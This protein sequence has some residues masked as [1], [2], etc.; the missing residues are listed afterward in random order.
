MTFFEFRFDPVA[1]VPKSSLLSDMRNLINNETFSDVTFIVEG[2]KVYGSRIHL[3]ARS[4][5]FKAMLY[6]GMKESFANDGVEI[7]DISYEVFLKVL[8]FLYTDEVEEIPSEMAVHL[9][10]ASERFLLVRLKSLCEGA[11]RKSVTPENVVSTLLAA[12][13]HHAESLRTM[14]LDFVLD[15]LDLVKATPSFSQLK[16][17]P[18]LLMEIIMRSST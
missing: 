11:I 17:E 14:T 5:H 8:E 7:E 9:L 16:T 6:G 10:M 3:A 4:E 18:D 13:I 15:N 12:H 2:K 1:T